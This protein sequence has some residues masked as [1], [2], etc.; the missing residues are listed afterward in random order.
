MEK[1]NEEGVDK[2]L[3]R[4][5][6]GNLPQGRT[7]LALTL[8]LTYIRTR[9]G[10]SLGHLAPS[11]VPVGMRHSAVPVCTSTTKSGSIFQS[12]PEPATSIFA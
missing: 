8:L 3:R 9:N 2:L 12:V 6:Q 11:C 4:L 5:K 1:G 7:S 10:G